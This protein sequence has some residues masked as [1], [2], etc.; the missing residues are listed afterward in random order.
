[1]LP[2]DFLSSEITLRYGTIQR[3]RGCFLYTR[4]GVRLTDMYQE[5]GRA[6]LGWGGS[7]AFT[8]FKDTLSRGLTG[9]FDT[10]YAPRITKAVCDLLAGERIV[11][12]SRDRNEALKTALLFSKDSTSFW[13]PWNQ[14]GIDW[15]NVD[16]VIVAP[17]LPWTP[18]LYFT[19]VKP[20]CV[21]LPEAAASARIPAPLAAA[22]ARSI[23]NMIDALQYREEKDWFIYDTVLTR[24]FTRR[25]PYLY[26]KVSEENYG[27]FIL[28][29]LDCGIVISPDYNVPSIV[30][31]GADK[32]V[33]GKLKNSP[34]E[35]V[36]D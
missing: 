16:A 21:S 35:A 1:M 9:S 27:A 13:R 15:N 33:F 7:S 19:A 10:D 4:K 18:D 5:G 24:Y 30:P 26:P 2:V 6:V 31:F 36:H 8:M 29:C 34:F 11:Y 12:I 25:G 23:Y 14:E 17:P 20:D 32:G 28:H 3:A 22:A